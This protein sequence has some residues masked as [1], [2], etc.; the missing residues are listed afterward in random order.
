MPAAVKM[1]ID[2]RRKYLTLM[3]L[4]ST[5]SILQSLASHLL[6]SSTVAL[7]ETVR[8][9]PFA[10]RWKEWDADQHGKSHRRTQMRAKEED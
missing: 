4:P 8:W 9:L 7:P 6:H 3:L 1:T 10:V 2:E 5:Y